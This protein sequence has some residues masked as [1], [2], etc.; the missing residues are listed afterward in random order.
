MVSMVAA[1]ATPS[2]AIHIH[3]IGKSFANDRTLCAVFRV[4]YLFGFA[5]G[6]CVSVYCLHAEI[7]YWSSNASWTKE[8]AAILFINNK[9]WLMSN[10]MATFIGC[11]AIDLFKYSRRRQSILFSLHFWGEIKAQSHKHTH[12]FQSKELREFPLNNR[13]QRNDREEMET[14]SLSA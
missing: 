5:F 13:K 9:C 7:Q 10:N 12:K 6:F 4:L 2:K 14:M 8:A 3:F 1:M 11:A